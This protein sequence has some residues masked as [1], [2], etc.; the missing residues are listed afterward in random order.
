MDQVTEEGDFCVVY[1][2]NRQVPDTEARLTAHY[3]P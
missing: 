2:Q 1:L 3:G